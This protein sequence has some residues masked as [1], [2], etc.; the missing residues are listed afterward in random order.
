M[1][2]FY[3]KQV[4]I[5]CKATEDGDQCREQA[6]IREQAK[7]LVQ[8]LREQFI[9]VVRNDWDEATEPTDCEGA[10]WLT[11]CAEIASRLISHRLPVMMWLHEGNR[12]H[13][14]PDIRYAVEDPEE[15]EADFYDKIYRR[16]I[17]IPWEIART[18]RC[19]I[20]ET[21]V[22]DVD[23][24]IKIYQNPGITRYTHSFCTEPDREREY[25]KEY[26]EKNYAFLGFGVWSVLWKAT[27][28]VIGRVGFEQPFAGQEELLSL[29]YMIAEPWQ[30]KG[31]AE[32]VCRAALYFAKEELQVSKVQVV[33]HPQNRPSLRLAE[34]LGVREW[35]DINEKGITCRKGILV[36]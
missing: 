18:H 27:G 3:L 36:P 26:I 12:Q 14:F 32:E 33:V 8:K 25:V 5:V 30:G 24:L 1:K 19:I 6:T 7:V 23:S 31:I 9:V 28:E 13:S 2:S 11:D 34:K 21:M 22:E 15:L 35:Q 4:Y 29:G 16:F 20:R 17:G 10:L